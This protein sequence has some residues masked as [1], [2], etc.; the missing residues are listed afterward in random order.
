MRL[1][2]SML[3]LLMFTTSVAL[4]QDYYWY[5]GTKIPLQQGNKWYVL[6]ET[7]DNLDKESHEVVDILSSQ[8]K[9]VAWNIIDNNTLHRTK[10][11]VYKTHSFLCFDGTQDM[12]VTHRFYVKIKQQEDVGFL[13]ELSEKYHL[14]FL[15]KT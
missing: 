12:Y 8:T 4:S 14:F 5:K 2:Y 6:Y 9:W 10:N 1:L 11:I 3:V 13:Q 15:K 7:D